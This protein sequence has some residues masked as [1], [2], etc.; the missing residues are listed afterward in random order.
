MNDETEQLLSSE[1][2][3]KHL[4]Q[5]IEKETTYQYWLRCNFE[6]IDGVIHYCNGQHDRSDECEM[7]KLTIE[8]IN[9]IIKLGEND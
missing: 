8:D 1:E 5:S 7:V 9:E 6:E 2:N 3:K 4:E